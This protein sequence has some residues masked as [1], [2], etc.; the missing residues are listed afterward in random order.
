MSSKNSIF[1]DN[2]YLSSFRK[3]NAS[4]IDGLYEITHIPEADKTHV[5]SLL[6]LNP[7]HAYAKPKHSISRSVRTLISSSKTQIKEY[8]PSSKFDQHLLP[9]TEQEQFVTLELPSHLPRI[10]FSE[11]YTYFYFRAVRFTFTAHG[12]KGLPTVA[13]LALLDTRY[14]DYQHACI[15]TVETTMKT[16]TILVTMF[17]NFNMP[18]AD[19][20]LLMALKFQIQ[21]VGAVPTGITYGAILHYQMTILVASMF[22][23]QIPR[24]DLLKLIPDTCLTSYEHHQN[25]KNAQPIQSTTH[26]FRKNSKGQVEI[27]FKREPTQKKLPCFTTQYAFTKAEANIPI[28]AFDSEEKLIYVQFEDGHMYWNICSCRKCTRRSRSTRPP[29]RSSQ[30][31]LQMAYEQSSPHVG[32]LGELSEKFDYFVTYTPLIDE[33]LIPTEWTDDDDEHNQWYKKW[34]WDDNNTLSPVTINM[35]HSPSP[36]K[37][38][39]LTS[40]DKNQT[41]H[42]WKVRN[43]T[44]RSPSGSIDQLSPAEKVLNWQSENAVQQNKILQKIDQSQQRIEKALQKQTQ[45]LLTPL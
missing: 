25:S 29:S 19:P 2:Q 36:E 7:Y 18:I 27:M 3:S 4:K 8:V 12:R 22:P 41:T 26:H 10:W 23:R 1:E 45:A 40:F 42:F 38:P 15:G 37:F 35:F 43:P 21:I 33:Q 39:P 32:L 34:D 17:S 20:Q 16:G 6:L 5:T 11:G 9:T 30:Q 13:R 14:D 31:K 44:T 24:N 28:Y